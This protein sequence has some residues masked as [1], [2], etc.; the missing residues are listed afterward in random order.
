MTDFSTV[1]TFFR[2]GGIFMYF[3]LATAVVVIA[4][5]AERF[6]VV[7]R[8]AGLNSRKLVDDLVRHVNRRDIAGARK[9]ARVSD[10]PAAQ[11]ATAMLQITDGDLARLQAAADDAATLAL[12]PLSRRLP[13]LNVLA[14]V[15]TLLGL[16]GRS[17]V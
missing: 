16:L 5:S 1:A 7:G 12:S 10:A 14:N 8:A 6:I 2:E 11:V 13:H 17:R 3:M 9:V 4:I 15:A